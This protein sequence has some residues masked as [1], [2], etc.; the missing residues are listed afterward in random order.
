ML[1][2]PHFIAAAVVLALTVL[3]LALPESAATRL[4][5][6]IKSIFLPVFGLASSMPAAAQRAGD[7]ATPRRVLLEELRRLRVENERLQVE[8]VELRAA[9]AENDRLRALLQ[10]RTGVTG[11]YR[12]ARVIGRDPANWWRSLRIDAG[13]R[14]GVVTNAVVLTPVGLVGRVA[15]VGLGYSEVLLV[16]DSDCRVAAIA[17]VTR[18]QGVV[19]PSAGAFDPG[20]VEMRY[21]PAN[22]QLKPGQRVLTSGVGGVFPG[23]IPV[24]VITGIGPGDIEL[25]STASVKLFVNPNRL[26][27]VW[28]RLK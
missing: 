8:G 7:A 27:E 15:Q 16:G 1:R 13:T 11:Q 2:K 19:G 17:E 6:G 5:L 21:L 14:E 24:G 22:A 20:T 25:N 26:E 23:G 12:L 28:V 9:R 10:W 3:L 18:E 4:K